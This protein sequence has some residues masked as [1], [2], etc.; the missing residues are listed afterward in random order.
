MEMWPDEHDIAQQLWPSQTHPGTI[1]IILQ[2]VPR[3]PALLD[4]QRKKKSTKGGYICSSF[5][6]G[7]GLNWRRAEIHV[8]TSGFI[9]PCFPL[10]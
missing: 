4:I 9:S 1:N 6:R 5:V 8:W 10:E 7:V 2:L 3:S